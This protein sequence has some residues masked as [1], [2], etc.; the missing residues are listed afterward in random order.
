MGEKILQ[1]AY[2]TLIVGVVFMAGYIIVTVMY[3]SFKERK[4]FKK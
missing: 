2:I 3:N 4:N 1:A